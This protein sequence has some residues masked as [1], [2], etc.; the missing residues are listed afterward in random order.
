M[1]FLLDQGDISES[2]LFWL[3]KYT[4]FKTTS[5]STNKITDKKQFTNLIARISGEPLS[6]DEIRE[7]SNLFSNIGAKSIKAYTG[8]VCKLVEYLAEKKLS[9]MKDIDTDEIL[10]FLTASTLN[11][12]DATK[13]NY[14][15]K[16]TNFFKYISMNNESEPDSDIG[17]I[18][19]LDIS[20]WQGLTGKS[21]NMLPEYLTTDEV[22]AL[23]HFISYDITGKEKYKFSS[24]RAKLLYNFVIRVIL[25]TGMRISE[26]INIKRDKI[27]FK[28]DVVGF[29]YVGKGNKHRYT[30]I[31]KRFIEKWLTAWMQESSCKE[32][33]LLC[34]PDGR[35]KEPDNQAVSEDTI[36]HMIMKI[37]KSANIVKR[38]MGAHLLRHTFATIIQEET[39]D[40]KLLQDLLGHASIETTAIYAHVNKN[41]LKAAGAKVGEIIT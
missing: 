7:I 1:K 2:L 18:Y 24:E 28:S 36:S 15:N 25:L 35:K 6:V 30:E 5:L 31:E 11:L 17:Y 13:K 33:Y 32:G 26:V 40:L 10:E 22:H 27:V 12:K 23:L 34:S 8:P 9:K 4:K 41:K 14:R 21:G 39:E 20:R 3:T 19:M 16:M 29:H 37:L 38:K